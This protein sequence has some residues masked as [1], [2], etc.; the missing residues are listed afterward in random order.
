MPLSRRRPDVEGRRIGDPVS[1]RRVPV[2]PLVGLH[3]ESQ[4]RPLRL[5]SRPGPEERRPMTDQEVQLFLAD[6]AIIILFARLF[7][8]AAK[9]LGQPP[10]VG[11]IIA[12]I[13]LGPTLFDGR[14]TATLFPITV[15]PALSALATLGVVM[16]MFAVGYL[17]DLRLI[18][19]PRARGR[20]RVGQFDHSSAGTWGLGSAHGWPAVIMCIRSSPSRYSWA[21]PWRSPRFRCWRASSP[22]ATCTAPG[23]AASRSPAPRPTTCWLGRCWPSWPPPPAPEASSSGCSWPRSTRASCSVWSARSCAGWWMTY[24]RRGRLTPSVFAAV[25]VGL[26]LSSYA[27]EWMGLKYI[28]GAFLFG[29]VMPGKGPRPPCGRKSSMGWS[30]SPSWCCCPCS[31]LCRD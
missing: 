10:V 30:R 18:R 7:G 29:V 31:S 28:F 4:P 19:G 15:R 20:E 17:L 11:E 12:G 24:Q 8:I 9:R 2:P 26:L 1:N 5:T 13:L 14:I 27:T 23:S 3:N 22:T 21:R 6:L 25:L 16:F